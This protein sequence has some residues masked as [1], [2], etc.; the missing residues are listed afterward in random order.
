MVAKTAIVTGAAGSLGS[1]LSRELVETGWNV[2]MLDRDRAGLEKAFDAIGEDSHGEAAMYPMDLAG[3]NPELVEALLDT[4]NTEFGGLNALVHCAVHFGGLTPQ[5]Q[6]QPGEWLT[7]MQVNLNAPWLLGTMSMPLLRRSG[8]G[9]ML[10]LLDDLDRVRGALWG[11][12]EVAK[13]ALAALVHQLAQE[14]RTD[15]IDVK[16]VNPG[17]MRSPV[18]TRVYYAENP[19]DMRPPGLAAARIAG[20]LNGEEEWRESVVDLSE[21]VTD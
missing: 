21:P 16:G 11:A 1:A 15:A 19:A 8:K 9:K 10:F 7:G 4:V 2:V 17:P 12:Y 6:V 18:R 3:A 13:H 5:E 14:T 20:Y